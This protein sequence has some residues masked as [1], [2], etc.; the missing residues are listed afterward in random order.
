[1]PKL[2]TFE[3][4]DG[5]GKT[6]VI[7]GLLPILKDKYKV[8]LSYE[9][10]NMFGHFAKFGCPGLGIESSIYLWWLARQFEQNKPEYKSADIVIKDR[11][12]DSTYVYQQLYKYKELCNINYDPL[13]FNKPD[14]TFILDVVNIQTLNDRIKTNKKDLFETMDGTKL[15]HR[16]YQYINLINIFKE[17]KFRIID[18]DDK[19]IDDIIGECSR[20]IFNLI[21]EKK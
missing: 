19:S 21:G 20:E 5:C 6:T 16:R 12:Y 18:C 3:G 9:P 7:D 1:M 15:I 11:Y 4:L 10:G 13:Y 8:Y 2:I 14:L 17:R